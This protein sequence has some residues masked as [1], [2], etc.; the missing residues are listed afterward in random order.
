[1]AESRQLTAQLSCHDGGARWLVAKIEQ[2][3]KIMA[4]VW[5]RPPMV[6]SNPQ[7]TREST[8]C[9]PAELPSSDMASAKPMLMPAPIEAASPTLNVASVLP[10][11][12]AAATK[13]QSGY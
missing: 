6:V 8:V 11:A 13:G 9:Q 5:P 4:L 2:S 3:D 10:V 12:K 7:T 1:L